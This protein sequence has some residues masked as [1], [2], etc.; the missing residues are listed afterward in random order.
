M[1]NLKIK[2]FGVCVLT[3]VILFYLFQGEAM[4]AALEIELGCICFI[5]HIQLLF[6]GMF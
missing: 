1:L 5:L 2:M 4:S 3:V 6:L